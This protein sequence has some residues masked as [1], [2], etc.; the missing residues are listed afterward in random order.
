MDM[1]MLGGSGV[2]DQQIRDTGYF[3]EIGHVTVNATVEDMTI[4]SGYYDETAEKLMNRR[5]EEGRMPEKAGEL[6]AERSALD[7]MDLEEVQ[8]G[9][10]LTLDMRPIRGI[11]VKKTFTLVGILNEQN[12]YLENYDSNLEGMHF[13]ALLVSPEDKYAF[14]RTVEHRVLTYAPLITFNQVVRHAGFCIRQHGAVQGND[15][16]AEINVPDDPE[17][18]AI[19]PGGGDCEVDPLADQPVDDLHAAGGDDFF[20]VHQG[21]V[22]V[23][24]V[25]GF[26]HGLS[27]FG[28]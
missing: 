12:R 13:P 26:L 14:G 2:T 6:A 7:F 16:Q 5:M 20:A 1:F 24:Y 4:C 9:D 3:R 15:G 18:A 25:Q 28:M 10:T 8:V 27:S 17:G 22:Q 21:A 11:T 19:G 23:G